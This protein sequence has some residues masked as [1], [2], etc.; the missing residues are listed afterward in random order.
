MATQKQVRLNWS[1]LLGFDQVG[2]P[3]ETGDR[4]A[5]TVSG[6]SPRISGKGGRKAPKIGA[7]IGHKIGLKI[8]AK[9]GTKIGFK[10]APGS[11]P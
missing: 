3:T 4:S 10:P 2:K 9:S 8:G 11:R 1:R 5:M 6:L 7:K